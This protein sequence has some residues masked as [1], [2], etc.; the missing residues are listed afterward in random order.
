M[1]NIL[2]ILSISA[3]LSNCDSKKTEVKTTDTASLTEKTLFLSDSQVNNMQL[4]IQKIKY[5]QINPEIQASG[6][7]SLLPN[8]EALVS[9]YL[10]GRIIKIFVLEGQYVSKGSPIVELTGMEI[11]ELQQSFYAARNEANFLKLEFERQKD[12]R[13]KNI[14]AVAEFQAIESKF[15]ISQNQ[16]ESFGEKLKV[17]GI[18]PPEGDSLK[19]ADVKK[20]IIVTSPIEGYIFSLPALLGKKV[21]ESD[22]LATIINTSMLYAEIMVFEKDID[23]VKSGLVVDIDFVNQSL[24][25]IK[26]I[27]QSVSKSIDPDTRAVKVYVKFEQGRETNVLPE[28]AVKTKI[29]CEKE[30]YKSIIVPESA[31]VKEGEFEYVFTATPSNNGYDVKKIK[32][33]TLNSDANFVSVSGLDSTQQTLIVTENTYLV[34]VEW[35]KK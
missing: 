23:L 28:M 15:L 29:I 1:K 21:D 22:E 11:I 13:S 10:P 33:N 30:A 7:V 19:K 2:Y 16:M 4:N 6:K 31:I 35:A 3:I 9:A 25:N 18:Y 12:L 14:G 5:A 26:G 8:S 34:N 32:I 24:P 27:I 20:S 17:L